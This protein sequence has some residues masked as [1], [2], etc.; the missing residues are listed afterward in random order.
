VVG[1]RGTESGRHYGSAT[2]DDTRLPPGQYEIDHFPRFGL[3]IHL[4]IAGDVGKSVALSGA[5]SH[6]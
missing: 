1:P 5:P 4:K 2:T 3:R 6:V